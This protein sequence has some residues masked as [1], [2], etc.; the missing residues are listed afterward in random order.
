M[1]FDEMSPELRAEL[2]EKAQNCETAEE[3]MA[4]IREHGIEL[5]DEQLECI[6]G[7]VIGPKRAEDAVCPNN[8][9]KSHHFV[10][11]GRKRPGKIFGDWW[12]YKEERCELCSKTRWAF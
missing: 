3:R 4:F 12:P 9:G 6:A 2:K 7:G 11:T 10:R 1:T 8:D 5:T